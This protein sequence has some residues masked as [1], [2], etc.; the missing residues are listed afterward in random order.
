MDPISVTIIMNGG[1]EAARLLAPAAIAPYKPTESADYQP[2]APTGLDVIGVPEG[3]IEMTVGGKG[4]YTMQATSEP[5]GLRVKSARLLWRS[6]TWTI[7]KVRERF[8]MGAINGFT[9]D[10]EF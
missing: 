4:M 6:H 7:L 1:G 8:W 10:L 2:D 9:L 3:K 5:A